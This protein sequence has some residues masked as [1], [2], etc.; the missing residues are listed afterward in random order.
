MKL[1][2]KGH[3]IKMLHKFKLK[4]FYFIPFF[5]LSCKYLPPASKNNVFGHV[6]FL[7]LIAGYCNF[8]VHSA[9][10]LYPGLFYSVGGIHM[11]AC[12]HAPH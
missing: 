9:E 1:G 12:K 7:N 10:K 8:E 6:P 11:L 5:S 2:K 3:K 4:L